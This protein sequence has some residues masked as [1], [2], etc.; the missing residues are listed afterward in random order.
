MDDQNLV[1]TQ[2]GPHPEDMKD[3]LCELQAPFHHASV[4]EEEA[5]GAS[6]VNCSRG[7]GGFRERS[8]DADRVQVRGRLRVGVVCS[9]SGSAD[10]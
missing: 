6:G 10:G 1:L 8:D 3:H 5:Q 7:S 2:P 9:D 4:E